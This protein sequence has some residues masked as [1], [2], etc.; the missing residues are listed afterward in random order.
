MT[1]GLRALR[2]RLTPASVPPVPQAQVKASTLPLVCVPDFSAGGGAV[3]LAVGEVV[4]LVGPDGAQFL[5]QT[6]GDVDV[7]AGV[8]IGLGRDQ[9]EVRAD[10]PQEGDFFLGLRFR[11]DDHAFIAER[12]GDQREADAGIAGGALDDGAAGFER[13]VR[14][15]GADDGKA[16]AVLHRAAGG[17]EL[18]LAEDLA[19]RG[20]RRRA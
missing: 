18:G 10:H 1:L 17:A 16:G 12:V 11:H 14:L 13:A 20:L 4:E 6:A 15:G 19:P 5:G 7:V 2:A 8:L 3:A 9:A